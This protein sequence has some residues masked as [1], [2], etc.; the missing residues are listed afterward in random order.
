[1]NSDTLLGPSAYAVFAGLLNLSLL[2]LGLPGPFWPRG[3]GV[4][5]PNPGYKT[6]GD[7]GTQPEENISGVIDYTLQSIHFLHRN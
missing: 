6:S 5:L 4:G 2:N 1:M 3:W 7:L